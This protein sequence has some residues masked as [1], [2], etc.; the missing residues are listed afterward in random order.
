MIG[1]SGLGPF[2]SGNSDDQEK[3]KPDLAPES[4]E[5]MIANVLLGIMIFVVLPAI[6]LWGCLA[7]GR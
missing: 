2:G 3:P 6:C 1:F 7:V 4:R 5:E